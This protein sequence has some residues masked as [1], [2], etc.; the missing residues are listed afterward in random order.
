MFHLKIS[1]NN[2][3][4]K[5]ERVKRGKN[6]KR[7]CK[8]ARRIHAGWAQAISR[9][10]ARWRHCELVGGVPVRPR[11]GKT[12]GGLG[13][14][15]RQRCRP[16]FGQDSGESR[17]TWRFASIASRGRY[18]GET[19]T[20]TAASRWRRVAQERKIVLFFHPR[21]VW[22]PPH[23]QGKCIPFFCHAK[24][25]KSDRSAIGGGGRRT[26]MERRQQRRRRDSTSFQGWRPSA[27]TQPVSHC[28]E[29]QSA[30]EPSP[31]LFFSLFFPLLG[32]AAGAEL[33]SRVFRDFSNVLVK[34]RP[35]TILNFAS[36]RGMEIN[37]FF[38]TFVD[39]W[40]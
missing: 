4:T 1:A 7:K 32:L 36:F 37:L 10:P 15:L 26:G 16:A 5:Q 34:A 21:E 20:A 9:T 19:T 23:T 18:P 2:S 13:R 40:V 8:K 38:S 28:H 11:R 24:C 22:R 12:R 33:P 25:G 3:S 30:A 17:D 39:S 29:D 35:S 14:L 31:S 6:E 27:N